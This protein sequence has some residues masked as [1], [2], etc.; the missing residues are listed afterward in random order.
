MQD[1][2]DDKRPV[3]GCGRT[4]TWI[5]TA[6][7][8]R[9]ACER[10]EIDISTGAGIETQALLASWQW[11][12]FVRRFRPKA[13]DN[14]RMLCFCGQ[15]ISSLRGAYHDCSMQRC[16]LRVRHEDILR[17]LVSILIADTYPNYLDKTRRLCCQRTMVVTV[18][19]FLGPP[20]H[21]CRVCERTVR[22]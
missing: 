1:A 5:R 11:K 16:G 8:S 13:R 4:L 10:C 15:S 2:A 20:V 3:C 17:V 6:E 18:M 9:T 21:L 19:T 22:L 14:F 12:R 7:R